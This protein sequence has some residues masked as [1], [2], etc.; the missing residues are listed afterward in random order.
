LDEIK[1]RWRSLCERAITE[2]DSTKFLAIV[3]ELIDE[4]ETKHEQLKHGRFRS[5]TDKR[6]TDVG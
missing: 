3:H 1:E 5:P 4:L 2:K 6:P